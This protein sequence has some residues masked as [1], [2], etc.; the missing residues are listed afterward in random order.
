[1]AMS[2]ASAAQNFP[3][4]PDDRLPTFEEVCTFDAES[5]WDRL[6]PEQQRIIGVLAVK[7]AV[8]GGR[9][10]YEHPAFTRQQINEIDTRSDVL[11]NG[12]IEKVEPFW[13]DLYGWRS[14]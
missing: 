2:T 13:A 11:L 4:G 1:M 8:V 14:H 3:G 9:L 5:S 6:T 10:H 12:L 7:F